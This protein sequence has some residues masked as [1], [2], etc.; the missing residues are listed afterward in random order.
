MQAGDEI[1]TSYMVA[2]GKQLNE[3][4][5]HVSG[6]QGRGLAGPVHDVQ[7]GDCVYVKS[8]AEK[9]LKPQWEGPFQVLL[10]SFTTI[11]IKEQNA[12]VHHNRVEKAPR[13]PW[14]VTQVKPGKI[15][16]LWS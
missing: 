3:T 13:T 5:K 12:W 9:T 7:P 14:K 6:T 2:L 15:R 1:M 4:G 10:T 11:R 8:L 16:F